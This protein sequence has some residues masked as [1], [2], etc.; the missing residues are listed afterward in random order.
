M[1]CEILWPLTTSCRWL[2]YR[3]TI[4]R[5]FYRKEIKWQ[6]NKD[7]IYDKFEC[8]IYVSHLSCGQSMLLLKNFKLKCE[9]KFFHCFHQVYTEW[10]AKFGGQLGK[11]VVLLTGET[12][13]DLKLL[14][15]VRS[16]VKQEEMWTSQFM[17]F[18]Y[19]EFGV[20]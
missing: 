2:L 5:K 12:G 6:L 20:N 11:K 15:K 9:C 13:T 17:H 10:T 3:V 8:I 1:W 16:N 19:E 18:W 4:Y 7:E 14:A